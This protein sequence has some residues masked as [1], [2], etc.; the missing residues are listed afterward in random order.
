V[1][2]LS[3]E[4][5]T[6]TV[7]S[8]PARADIACFVGFVSVRSSGPAQRAQLERAL[9]V[10]GWG[11]GGNADAPGSLP[12][13]PRVLA[14]AIRPAGSSA[15]AFTV[16]L[17]SV[18]WRPNARGAA[19]TDLFARAAARLVGGAVVDWWTEYGWLTGLA[20]RS[21]A[22]LLELLD[23]PVPIDSWD[24][25]DALFAWDRRPTGRSELVDATLGAAVRR[26]FLH[27]GRKCYVVRVGDDWPL[28][29]PRS[30]RTAR[31]PQLLATSP[32]TPA[33]R[34]TWRGVGHLFGLP[35]VSFLCIPDLPDLFAIESTAVPLDTQA[36]ADEIERF[37]ECATPAAPDRF[38]RP[39]R[40]DAPRCD[41]PGFVEWA[42]C[43]TGVAALVRRHAPEVQFVASLPLP[44]DDAAL[45]TAPAMRD[46]AAAD[47]TRAIAAEV[48][49][50]RSAQHQ[51]AGVIQT[52]FVQLA[53]PWLHTRESARLPG[54]V[55][56]PEALLT[57]VLANNALTQ[58]TWRSAAHQPISGIAGLEPTLSR[59]D[60]Q[61]ELPFTGS[62][63][64]R[65]V[66]RTFR[67]RISIVAPTPRGFELL[68]DVTTDDDDTYR[69]ANVN[70]L[71][72][73]VVRAAR[74]IGEDTVFMNNGET[75]WRRIQAAL[76]E[77]L[78]TLWGEGA[79]SG[80]YAGDAFSVRC[81]RSTM[82]QS[83]IDAGRVITRVQFNASSPIE[84]IVIVFAMDEG[85]QVALI[86]RDP[87]AIPA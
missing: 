50:A 4:T 25:F 72:A 18:G 41:A 48:F 28:L 43:V 5:A 39:R 51:Q 10:L 17:E 38:R 59:R 58:G 74:L 47:R 40:F 60:L 20:G 61:R 24:A 36:P 15:T 53:Y 79:L 32:P 76:E 31:R 6:P 71:V 73:S 9:R 19:A 2:G 11:P 29:T 21:A 14:D 8:D 81:D 75:V 46:V 26:F 86:G 54:G 65:R 3:F 68:S 67:E 57:G 64:R 1:D 85:G 23:V 13:S 63:G 49:A 42:T 55:E 12:A 82:T 66:P 62:E 37:I 22:D 34:T 56:P 16:W 70:R 77:V 84:H 33:D 7:R 69:A 83:D 52:A 30:A 45:R 27:G 35:D 44:I 87:V 78:R 80:A